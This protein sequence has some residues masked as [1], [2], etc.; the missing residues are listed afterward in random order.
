MN[1]LTAFTFTYSGEKKKK[2]TNFP[3]HNGT[4]FDAKVGRWSSEAG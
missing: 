1:V 2:T 4:A 3:S